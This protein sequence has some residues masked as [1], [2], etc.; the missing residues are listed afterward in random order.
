MYF[1]Q[2]HVGVWHNMIQHFYNTIY[3]HSLCD[4]LVDCDPLIGQPCFSKV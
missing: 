2:M 1:D 3:I 4:L